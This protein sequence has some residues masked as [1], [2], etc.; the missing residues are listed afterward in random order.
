[1]T[2][3]E[4]VAAHLGGDFLAQVYRRTHRIWKAAV[5]DAAG[6]LTFDDLNEIITRQRLEPPRLR[7]S[8]KGE[9]VPLHRYGV[10]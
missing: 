3:T 8:V 9:I 5:P 7:L 1:M 2:A 4:S 6:L 10:P